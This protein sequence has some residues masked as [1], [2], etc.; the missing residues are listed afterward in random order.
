MHI[1]VWLHHVNQS[2]A[3]EVVC[4][5]RATRL[6]EEALVGV[7]LAQGLL[8]VVDAGGVPGAG[9]PTQQLFAQHCIVVVNR[10]CKSAPRFKPVVAG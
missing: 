4:R 7:P 6:S 3:L 1:H 9:K 5:E 2:E 8:H 10:L